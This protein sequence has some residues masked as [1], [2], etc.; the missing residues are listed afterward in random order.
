VTATRV[1]SG[2][3]PGGGSLRIRVRIELDSFQVQVAG[4]T[5]ASSTT[6]GA[7][8]GDVLVVATT[9]PDQV[10]SLTSC[11]LSEFGGEI[12]ASHLR[13]GPNRYQQV[14][15][16]VLPPAP[17]VEQHARACLLDHAAELQQ[18]IA[19]LT[20]EQV[21]VDVAA[22]ALERAVEAWGPAAPDA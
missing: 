9:L 2:S 3:S 20:G 7:V 8:G 11:Y 10:I 4:A 13:S 18:A 1:R 19:D 21:L 17:H 22:G 16:Q 14:T 6:I 12:A 15:A 5:V